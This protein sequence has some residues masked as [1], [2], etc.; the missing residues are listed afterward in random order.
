ML[1]YQDR[2]YETETETEFSLEKKW[3]WSQTSIHIVYFFVVFHHIL[4]F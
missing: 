1:S 4:D 3:F 2:K